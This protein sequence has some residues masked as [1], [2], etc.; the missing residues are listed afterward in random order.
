MTSGIDFRDAGDLAVWCERL[1]LR[2]H[3]I[4]SYTLSGVSGL[5]RVLLLIFGK[6]ITSIVGRLSSSVA[7]SGPSVVS[8]KRPPPEHIFL[9]FSVPFTV[10]GDQLIS[11]SLLVMSRRLV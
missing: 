4:T 1:N 3:Y 11:L 2:Q 9:Y 8:L 7:P 6:P 10:R 5:K